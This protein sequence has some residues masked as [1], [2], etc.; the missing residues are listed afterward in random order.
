MFSFAPFKFYHSFSSP[1]LSHAYMFTLLI[2]DTLLKNPR[3][4]LRKTKNI[5]PRRTGWPRGLAEAIKCTLTSL[6]PITQVVVS[7]FRYKTLETIL[8]LMIGILPSVPMVM[9]SVS[10]IFNVDIACSR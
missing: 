2:L 8:Y 9:A 5:L 7:F 10:L 1:A 4:P 6:V 3:E